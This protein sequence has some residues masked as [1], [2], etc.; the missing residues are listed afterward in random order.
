MMD[1]Y[2]LFFYIC[3]SYISFK[4]T[5]RDQLPKHVDYIVILSASTD[6]ITSDRI[7]H[8]RR[9]AKEFYDVKLIACG[10]YKSKFFEAKL[11]DLKNKL[12]LQNY[13][14]NTYEDALEVKKLVKEEETIILVT[15][16]SHQIRAL[17]TFLKFFKRDKIYCS[18]TNDL[19]RW[20]SPLFPTGWVASL[21]N[22]IKDRKYNS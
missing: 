11:S 21:L 16:H 7:E 10:K 3:L 18:P 22:Y 20:Y 15:S 6:L 13:S 9:L 4:Y 14:T 1:I 12:I 19:M 17:N 2:T 5:K 8:A